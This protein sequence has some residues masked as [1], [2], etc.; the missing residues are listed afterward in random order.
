MSE[1][2]LGGWASQLDI[3][4][5]A[6]CGTPARRP[7]SHVTLFPCS[8]PSRCKEVVLMSAEFTLDHRNHSMVTC[9]VRG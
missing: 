9:S 4:P 8:A 7:L 1:A 5:S 2:L 3:R 6:F